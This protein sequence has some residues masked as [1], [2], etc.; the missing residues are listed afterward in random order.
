MK[1]EK[2]HQR[3]RTIDRIVKELC[4]RRAWDRG[5]ASSHTS[6]ITHW[7]SHFACRGRF[8]GYVKRNVFA[9]GKLG[10]TKIPIREGSD[11]TRMGCPTS[12][13]TERSTPPKNCANNFCPSNVNKRKIFSSHLIFSF[14][15]SPS[16]SR[17]VSHSSQSAIMGNFTDTDWRAI[18]TIRTL[19]VSR[20]KYKQE[21]NFR[22]ADGVR[23]G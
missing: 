20:S 1:Q 7:R 6:C 15:T 19:A 2:E 16:S 17:I 11:G 12:L 18:N 10:D 14:L 22:D 5:M 4:E 9:A 21:P 23:T 3:R 8:H 13:I